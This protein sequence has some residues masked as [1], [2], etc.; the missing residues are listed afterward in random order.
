MFS[1]YALIPAKSARPHF[2]AAEVV[3]F[4]MPLDIR[5]VGQEE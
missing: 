1:S 2:S 3:H 4:A 5:G